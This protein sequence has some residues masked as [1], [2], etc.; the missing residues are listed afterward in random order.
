LKKTLRRLG[1]VSAPDRA[2]CWCEAGRL[3]TPLSFD[4]YSLARVTSSSCLQHPACSLPSCS[5]PTSPRPNMKRGET[6][7][8]VPEVESEP[9]AGSRAPVLQKLALHGRRLYSI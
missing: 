8:S 5:L 9:M 3:L 1:S 4:Y 6:L 7:L 2:P